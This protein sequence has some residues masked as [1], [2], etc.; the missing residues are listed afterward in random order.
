MTVLNSG[1]KGFIVFAHLCKCN[2]LP[3]ACGMKCNES[4][5][6]VYIGFGM[7]MVESLFYLTYLLI[8]DCRN[9]CIIVRLHFDR[10]RGQHLTID[11]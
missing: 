9:C 2:R 11:I 1:Y 8:S 7:G 6:W 10:C 4:S 3:S 5:K